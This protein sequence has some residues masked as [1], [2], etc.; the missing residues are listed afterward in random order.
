MD[1]KLE[2][3]WTNEL[4]KWQKSGLSQA[5]YCRQNKLKHYRLTYWKKKL[6]NDLSPK[7]PFRLVEL[8]QAQGADGSVSVNEILQIRILSNGKLE[9]E[10]DMGGKFQSRLFK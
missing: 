5:E 2:N 10:V 6:L 7:Q 1:N 9:L 4:K 3:Y 8:N